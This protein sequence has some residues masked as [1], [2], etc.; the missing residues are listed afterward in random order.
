[1]NSTV[2]ELLAALEQASPTEERPDKTMRTAE[3]A[4]FLSWG[5]SRVRAVLSQLIKQGT[6]V[7]VRIKYRNIAGMVQSVTAYRLIESTEETE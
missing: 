4:E 2:D 3:I 5:M 1:M 6:V 7:P